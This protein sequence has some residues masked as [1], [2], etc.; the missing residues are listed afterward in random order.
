MFDEQLTH[1]VAFGKGPW[2]LGEA[3]ALHR[4]ALVRQP[5][6]V[7]G[8]RGQGRVDA[9]PAHSCR[10]AHRGVEHFN[11]CHGNLLWVIAIVRSSFRQNTGQLDE[12][13]TAASR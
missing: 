6:Q 5:P 2:F 11:R 12:R 3:V 4:D 10:T 1:Q 8:E 7:G 13:V 9:G